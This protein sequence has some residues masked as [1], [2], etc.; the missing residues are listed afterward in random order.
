M[1]IWANLKTDIY[2]WKK[3]VH[4]SFLIIKFNI[5]H[6]REIICHLKD[7][8]AQCIEDKKGLKEIIGELGKIKLVYLLFKIER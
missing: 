6:K 4:C 5:D 3:V 1:L 2:L 7:I 8:L